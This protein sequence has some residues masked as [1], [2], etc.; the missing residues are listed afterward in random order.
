MY[1]F[2]NYFRICEEKNLLIFHQEKTT[3]TTNKDAALYKEDMKIMRKMG[4]KS[5][6]EY[7]SELRDKIKV[8]D[9][10]EEGEV[11]DHIGITINSV[12]QTNHLTF[13]PEELNGKLVAVEQDGYAEEG[14][15]FLVMDLTIKN[16]DHENFQQFNLVGF[17]IETSRLT[18]CYFDGYKDS[19]AKDKFILN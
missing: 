14:F 5:Q 3:E 11:Y 4:K 9:M 13:I 12:Y 15:T 16:K 2:S 18:A 1:D 6:E 17:N 8:F 10:G 7:Q 19:T